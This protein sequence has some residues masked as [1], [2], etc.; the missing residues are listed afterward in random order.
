VEAA[1]RGV[2]PV[3]VHDLGIEFLGVS[4]GIELDGLPDAD[5]LE[6]L[7]HDELPQ[8]KVFA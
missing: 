6:R 5:A 4:D 3:V 8:A 7:I 1:R 2:R